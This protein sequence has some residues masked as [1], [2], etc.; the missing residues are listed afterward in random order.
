MCSVTVVG[1][2]HVDE[3]CHTSRNR[4]PRLNVSPACW[5]KKGE[6]LELLGGQ[7]DVSAG[8]PR[9]AGAEPDFQRIE[10][11]H[12]GHLDCATAAPSTEFGDLD[13]CRADVDRRG[14]ED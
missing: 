2:C 4:S 13:D 6:K 8:N 9:P 12:I 5:A 7:L 14:V 10:T 3:E 1:F 11:Q